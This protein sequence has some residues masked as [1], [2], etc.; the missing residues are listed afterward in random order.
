MHV[1]DNIKTVHDG[2]GRFHLV[3]LRSPDGSEHLRQVEDHGEAACVLPYDPVRHVVTLV[4]QP[5][6]GPLFAGDGGVLLEAPAGLTDGEAPLEAARR[7]AMEETGLRLSDLDSVGAFWTMPGCATERVHL[8]LAAYGEADRVGAGGG[9][10]QEGEE[11]EVVE[12]PVAVAA[13]QVASGGICD[14]KTVLLLQA[15]QI[16]HPAL[17]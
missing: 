7:E 16:R 6:V 9:V 8:F 4:R 12:M 2:W 1:I 5:R 15:L 11:I 3:T 17:F 13:R 10:P 14:M